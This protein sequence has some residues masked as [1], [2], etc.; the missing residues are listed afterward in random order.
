MQPETCHVISRED[1]SEKPYVCEKLLK[2][3]NT[4]IL[5]FSLPDL[6]SNFLKMSLLFNPW[7]VFLDTQANFFRELG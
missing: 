4:H 5:P 2:I 1:H 7:L 3:H 6:L